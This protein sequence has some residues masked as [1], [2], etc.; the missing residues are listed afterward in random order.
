MTKKINLKIHPRLIHESYIDLTQAI[1][2][3]SITI[4]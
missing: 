4:A 3:I 2:E 1:Q